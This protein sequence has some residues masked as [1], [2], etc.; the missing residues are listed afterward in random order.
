MTIM[1]QQQRQE[2]RAKHDPSRPAAL[3]AEN[4]TKRFPG[5]V[6][7]DDVSLAIAPGEIVALLGQNG[8]GKSTLIQIFAGVHSAGSY[9]GDIRLAGRPYRPASVADAEASGVALVP[10]E[11][12]IA[13][14]LSVAENLFLNA[15]PL[16]WGLLD[17]PLRQAMASAALR[18]FGLDIDPAH[19][20]KVLDLATQQLALIARALSKKIDLLILDEP[21]A[22]LTEGEAQR[23]FDRMR[24]LAERGVAVIFV[25]HR[26][27]EVFAVSNRI[28]IMRDGR[29]SGSHKT[30][31]VTRAMV[32][33][34]MV[35]RAMAPVE[36]IGHA[37]EGS[38][39]IVENLTVFDTDANDRARVAGISFTLARGEIVGLFGLVGSGCVEAALALYGAWPG[40]FEGTITIEA[41]PVTV[42]APTVALAHGLRCTA[43]QR[44]GCLTPRRSRRDNSVLAPR[45]P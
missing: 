6:A 31:E 27:A 3:V 14:D 45:P 41:S 18:D 40:R 8:A 2:D 39:L 10:Q 9:A 28:V 33:A 22:A 42:N 25:T 4:V 20:M 37:A 7:V 43:Q 26:L 35:G 19:P 21:T 29:I 23:L 30:R 44:R 1:G 34:Q 13:P 12:N 17:H 38:A 36:K 5:V 32:V 11:I 15:E 16:K 24:V